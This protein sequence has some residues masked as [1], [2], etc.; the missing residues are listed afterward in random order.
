MKIKEEK[1]GK[2]PSQM[3]D[4]EKVADYHQKLQVLVGNLDQKINQ[5]NM[6]LLNSQEQLQK[7][8]EL[9]LQK[10]DAIFI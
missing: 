5:K 3:T 10:Y 8:Q 1:E 4:A 7:F 9:L 6:M 2:D